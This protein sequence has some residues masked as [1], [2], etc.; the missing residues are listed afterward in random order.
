M[1]S[2]YEFIETVTNPAI[3]NKEI[4]GFITKDF[5]KKFLD[6]REIVSNI[7]H[8]FQYRPDKLAAYYYNN[9]T[10]YWIIC[11]FNKII[12]PFVEPKP[13]DILYLPARGKNLEFEHY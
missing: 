8:G 2:R 6:G 7:Q 5:I 9:P 11:D 13:G 1:A 12:D 10:Y 4:K 3:N